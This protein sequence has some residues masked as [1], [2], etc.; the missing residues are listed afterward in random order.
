MIFSKFGIPIAR[1]IV[2]D[3]KDNIEEKV[4][5][6]IF[7]AIVKSQIAIGSRKKAGLIQV[8]QTTEEAISLCKDYFQKKVAE[9][10]VEAILIEE[11]TDIEHEYYCSIALDPSGRQ[12]FI[13]ASEKG[14]IDIEGVAK[15]NP[16]AII[17]ESFSIQEGLRKEIS[18]KIGQ[19]LGFSDSLLDL[20]VKIFK[21]LWDQTPAGWV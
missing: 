7:P 6:F 9:F 21:K 19:S 8:A 15:S 12:F 1:S 17:K 3:R 14:G 18:Q 10:Q 4:K 20:A 5:S 13:I 11:L 2:I 16:E